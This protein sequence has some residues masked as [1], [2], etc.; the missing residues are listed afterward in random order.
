MSYIIIIYSTNTNY[1]FFKLKNMISLNFATF[2]FSYII[3]FC[4][5]SNNIFLDEKTT[6]IINSELL[7]DDIINVKCFWVTGFN[8]FDISH[9]KINDG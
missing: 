8:V 4:L 3:S 7:M 9:L 1:Y 6:H 5:G 2:I